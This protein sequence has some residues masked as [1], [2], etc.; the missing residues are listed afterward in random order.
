MY[1]SVRRSKRRKTSVV[2]DRNVRAKSEEE[3]HELE[4]MKSANIDGGN[5]LNT[6]GKGT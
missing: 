4:K 6:I 2:N 3:K 5:D 1:T